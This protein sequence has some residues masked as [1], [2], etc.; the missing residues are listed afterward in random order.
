MTQ[1]RSVGQPFLFDKRYYA[2][3]AHRYWRLGG[4][5]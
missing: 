4:E 5:V 2:V 3:R 1:G